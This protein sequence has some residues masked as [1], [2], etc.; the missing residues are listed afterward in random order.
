VAERIERFEFDEATVTLPVPEGGDFAELDGL[1][2][3]ER[4]LTW[5]AAPGAFFMI[6]AGAGDAYATPSEG[7][8]VVS[9]AP[10]PLA[11]S[12]ARRVV[13]RSTV[14]RPRR[15]AE[16]PEGQRSL[17]ERATEQLSDLLFVPG[18]SQHLRIGY[19]VD[20]GAPEA[21][22]AQLARMLDRVEVLPHA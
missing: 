9:D 2:D 17:P 3:G 4:H 1:P 7:A 20:E 11:G 6:S 15:L 8:C 21:V 5:T 14:R 12:R 16:A 18:A 19:R 10:A 22:R 13:L